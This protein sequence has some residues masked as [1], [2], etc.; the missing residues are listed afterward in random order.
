[1]EAKAGLDAVELRR[2]YGHRL[3][4][5]GNM[6]VTTWPGAGEDEL[7][8]LVLSKLN[9]AK[10]GGFIFASD[11]SVPDNVPGSSYDYVIKTV[12]RHGTYPLDLCEFDL[13][14]LK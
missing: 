13:P 9:A 1:M 8:A 12:R 2:K 6:D 4:F 7:R 5:C 10:G 11:H 3:A 14:D